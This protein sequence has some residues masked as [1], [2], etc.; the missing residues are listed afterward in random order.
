M[1]RSKMKLIALDHC[2]AGGHGRVS[3]QR[4]GCSAPVGLWV[5]GW[6]P[7]S[8][9]SMSNK[10]P[11]SSLPLFVKLWAPVKQTNLNR[12]ILAVDPVLIGG[13]CNVEAVVTSNISIKDTLIPSRYIPRGTGLPKNLGGEKKL[14]IYGETAICCCHLRPRCHSCDAHKNTHTQLVA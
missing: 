10:V 14:I 4:V 12:L 7:S 11:E 8:F 1:D 13:L 3:D 5:V 2:R 6:L 9:T